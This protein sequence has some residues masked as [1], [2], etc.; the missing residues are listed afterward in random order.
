[1]A[2][3]YATDIPGFTNYMRITPELFEMIKTRLEPHALGALN[4]N[5]VALKKPKNTEP[6][7]QL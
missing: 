7:P 3:L 5:H 4:R 1:M 6:V 2:E